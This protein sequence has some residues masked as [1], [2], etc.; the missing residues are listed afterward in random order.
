M[1]EKSDLVNFLTHAMAAECYYTSGVVMRLQANDETGNLYPEKDQSVLDAL[2]TCGANE[3][4]LPET[5]QFAPHLRNA[6][7]D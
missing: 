2:V 3:A 1:M 5:S 6:L 7:S 4:Q